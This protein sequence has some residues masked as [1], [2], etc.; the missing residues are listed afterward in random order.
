[1]VRS[2]RFHIVNLHHLK[3]IED[4]NRNNSKSA[5]KKLVIGND[6]LEVSD[7]YRKQVMDRLYI[8]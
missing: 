3:M 1:M 8:L 6:K 7:K 5:P 2:S 4:G